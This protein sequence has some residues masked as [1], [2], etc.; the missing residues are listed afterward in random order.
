MKDGSWGTNDDGI[1]LEDVAEKTLQ[2]SR[3]EICD[4]CEFEKEI[5]VVGK[6][7]EKCGCVLKLKTKMKW[8]H[9]PID[10]W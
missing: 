7:C 1:E 3:M 4:D 6:Y 8:T 10:K 5:K 2:E 9:C